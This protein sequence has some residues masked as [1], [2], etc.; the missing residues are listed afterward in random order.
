VQGGKEVPGG[1]QYLLTL[2]LVA[3]LV[4]FSSVIGAADPS[5]V[6]ARGGLSWRAGWWDIALLPPEKSHY[7][8]VTSISN[9]YSIKG[10]YDSFLGLSAVTRRT[11]IFV[12]WSLL[13]HELYRE[14]GLKIGFSR[15]MLSGFLRPELFASITGKRV[16]GYGYDTGSG[17][18]GQ[19]S[20]NIRG[21]ISLAFRFDLKEGK[22]CRDP[23]K[24]FF[25]SIRHRRYAFLFGQGYG[26]RYGDETRVGIEVSCGED[27]VLLSG[28]RLDTEEV[29]AGFVFRKEL[30]FFSFC[31][32]GHPVLGN[33][34][35]AG[36]GR[37][38]RR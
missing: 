6:R 15:E 32:S 7:R 2:F 22:S 8:L 35:A 14:D 17:L 30:C 37:L 1:L 18:K 16:P 9:P 27:A 34:F 29:S 36:V 28:Y 24:T 20:S 4:L 25:L 3:L 12:S 10:L 26:A 13:C 23:R 5:W 33:T 11:G 21:K 31:W 38:W 19:L